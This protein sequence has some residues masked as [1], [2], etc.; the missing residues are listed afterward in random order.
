MKRILRPL[1]EMGRYKEA[2]VKASV[3][4]AGEGLHPGTQGKRV[5]FSNGKTTVIDGPFTETRN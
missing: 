5:K 2:L 1:T 4:L 3:L